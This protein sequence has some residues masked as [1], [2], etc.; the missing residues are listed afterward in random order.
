MAKIKQTQIDEK[1]LWVGGGI[2]ALI[3]IIFVLGRVSGKKDS[4]QASDATPN[5][6]PITIST[7][8]GSMDWNPSALVKKVHTAFMV[9]WFTG[10][11]DVMKELSLLQDVQLKAVAEGYHKVYGSTLRKV[12]TEAW[13]VGNNTA[14]YEVI[15]RMD[16]LQIP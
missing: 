16:V 7:D 15:K 1:Y 10:R 14:F 4:N 12:L 5:I 9:N 11:G 6:N 8:A 13:V 3:L 2:L